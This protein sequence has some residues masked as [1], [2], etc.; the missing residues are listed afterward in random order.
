M[1]E[2]SWPNAGDM[3]ETASLSPIPL[4]AGAVQYLKEHG[5]N[6]PENLIPPEY[7]ETAK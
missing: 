5:V 6:P 4:H 7:N 3:L 2:N 1:W